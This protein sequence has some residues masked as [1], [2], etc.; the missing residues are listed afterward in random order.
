MYRRQFMYNYNTQ[1]NKGEYFTPSDL[2]AKM[3]DA[4]PTEL[5]G[6]PVLEPTCGSGN[7]VIA[8][9]DKMV[10]LGYDADTAISLVQA[11]E[12]DVET[13]KVCEERVKNWM[14]EHNCKTSTFNVTTHDASKH[15]FDN[16][17][18]VFTNPPFGSY[19]GGC[20]SIC[21]RIVNNTCKNKAAIL[22]VK[23][24]LQL[25]NVVQINDVLFPGI[26]VKT[27]IAVTYP[28]KGKHWNWY[29]EFADII[30]DHCKYECSKEEANYIAIELTS[31]KDL[32]RIKNSHETTCRGLYLKLTDKEA[33]YMRQH[34][35]N[36][37]REQDYM[38]VKDNRARRHL[39]IIRHA[40]N[41]RMRM[42]SD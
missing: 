6:K 39:G 28:G 9:L 26:S 20:S 21:K 7:L 38:N 29:D 2:A 25:D 10:E 40:I 35:T 36:T 17:E 11:N 13:A 14:N 42:Y 24:T 16:Y 32:L 34:S 19:K 3:I 8:L 37:Q 12:I 33:E 27:V 31:H 23:R 22:L 41:E 18:F 15:K 4:V 5:W 30:D 1:Y